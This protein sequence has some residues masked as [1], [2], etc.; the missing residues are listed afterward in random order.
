MSFQTKSYAKQALGNAG[1]ISKAFHHYANTI[2]GVVA[3]DDVVVGGFVQTKDGTNES[4]V[5]GASGVAINGKILGVVVRDE[6][7][8]SCL[9][10]GSNI[11]PKG[12]NV[13]ILSSGNIFIE[14]ETQ[15][16][17][18]QFVSLNKTTGALV[19][20]DILSDNAF[21]GFVVNIGNESGE[22]IIEITTSGAN[23]A[24]GE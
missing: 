13:T 15:A 1:Q 23:T 10:N 8:S 16:K 19:F 21:T 20:E 2:S 7:I 11:V 18:G 5:V 17:R 22:G 14:V 6:L 12:N 3:S 4:E 9:T 24:K